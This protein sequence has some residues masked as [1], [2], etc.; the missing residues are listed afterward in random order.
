M[1]IITFWF[2]NSTDNKVHTD[3]YYP[4][5]GGDKT[6]YERTKSTKIIL[7]PHYQG[8]GPTDEEGIPVAL[9]SVIVCLDKFCP[10]H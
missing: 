2:Y 4:V 1:Y 10:L 3:T 9:R 7:A 8:M 6:V 5:E